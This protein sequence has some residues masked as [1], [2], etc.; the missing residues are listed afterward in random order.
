MFV[1]DKTI[2]S[3]Y[4][5]ACL[6]QDGRNYFDIGLD[7]LLACQFSHNETLF[8]QIEAIYTAINSR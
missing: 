2:S 1:I 7:L 8:F 6:V 3:N 5:F 4:I